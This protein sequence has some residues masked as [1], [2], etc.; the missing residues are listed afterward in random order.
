[1]VYDLLS[2]GRP[3]YGARVT[4]RLEG[5]SATHLEESDKDRG[6]GVRGEE[7]GTWANGLKSVG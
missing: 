5:I 6:K 3:E 7:D 2:L 4:V 1:M